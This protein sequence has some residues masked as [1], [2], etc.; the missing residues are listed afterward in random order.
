MNRLIVIVGPTG[1]G[2]TQ[3]AIRLAQ[4]YKGEIINADRR[5]VSRYMDIGTAKPSREEFELVPHHLFD[6]VNPD[7]E[8]NLAIYKQLA[9]DAINNILERERLPLLVGGTGQYIRAVVEGWDIPKVAPEFTYRHSLEQRAASGGAGDLYKELVQVDPNAAQKI[10]PNNIRRIIRALEVSRYKPF[11][12]SIGKQSPPYGIDIIGLTME[13]KELY[14]R[15]DDR[16]E[17]MIK[18][19]FVEEVKRLLEMGYSLDL[20]SLSSI[21]YREIGQ[22]LGGN[23]KLEEAIYKLK[24]GTHRFIRHQYA[25][26]KLTDERIAWRD[27]HN[28]SLDL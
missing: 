27:T 18:R 19:G 5:Q 25:W 15:V 11:S 28:A 23:M 6:I 8:F 9:S 20:P 1:V 24:T 2:K 21:G 4:K 14:R 10:D 7:A 16:V 12:Q 17:D 3:F 26:F 22:Y 13:R